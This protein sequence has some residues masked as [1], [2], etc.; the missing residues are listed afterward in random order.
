MSKKDFTDFKEMSESD[1]NALYERYK[2]NLES[3]LARLGT[4]RVARINDDAFAD[5]VNSIEQDMKIIMFRRLLPDNGA[6]KGKT[7][8]IYAFR[9]SRA[10][11]VN[12]C[13]S[14]DY[15]ESDRKVGILVALKTALDCVGLKVSQIPENL[16][17]EIIYNMHK[18]H[19]N[20]ETLALVI[21]ACTCGNNASL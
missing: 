1:H 7:A 12:L 19:V 16:R 5:A 3:V 9:L 14:D 21:D 18:R 4:G 20:Q 15:H 17:Q 13:P 6:S 8:G 10:A 11:I 2:N